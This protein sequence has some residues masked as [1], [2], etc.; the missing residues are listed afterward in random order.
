GGELE[1]MVELG[2]V[3]GPRDLVLGTDDGVGQALVVRGDGVPLRGDLLPEPGEGVDE[4]AFE[5][6][7]VSDRAGPQRGKESDGADG[8]G[9]ACDAVRCARLDEGEHVT[10]EAGVD[11]LLAVEVSDSGR[12][13]GCG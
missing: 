8:P 5:G 1:L 10:V 6:Q 11:D 4:V 12:S 2:G 9:E 7:E 3:G 13:V